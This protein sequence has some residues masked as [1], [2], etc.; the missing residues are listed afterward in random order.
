MLWSDHHNLGI[1]A[2]LHSVASPRLRII[3]K[4]TNVGANCR[5]VVFTH[6]TAWSSA[7]F[8]VKRSDGGRKVDVL[9]RCKWLVVTATDGRGL[10]GCMAF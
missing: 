2:Q 4:T 9:S 8:A 3:T 10:H 7:L 1:Y 5:V 6:W